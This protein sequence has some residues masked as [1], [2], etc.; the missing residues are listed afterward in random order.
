MHRTER[1]KRARKI[2]G[3]CT[4]TK[5]RC[6]KI[7]KPLLTCHDAEACLLW[8]QRYDGSEKEAKRIADVTQFPAALSNLAEIYYQ[9]RRLL[10]AFA[11]YHQ[12]ITG[13]DAHALYVLAS[14]HRFGI[15]GC[16]KDPDLATWYQIRAEKAPRW[17]VWHGYNQIHM[18]NDFI[19]ADA[20]GL[21]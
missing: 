3:G 10:D 13:E 19:D 20:T 15:D 6:K 8:W 11:L 1:L 7:L 14:A 9:Q 4:G 2:A 12:A 17:D 5:R 21:F 16:A 18:M